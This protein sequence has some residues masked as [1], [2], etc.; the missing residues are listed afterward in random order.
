V[1]LFIKPCDDCMKK[2]KRAMCMHLLINSLSKGNSL[3][4]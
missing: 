1:E 3:S 4:T 2:S